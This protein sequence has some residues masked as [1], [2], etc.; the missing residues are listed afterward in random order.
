M[1]FNRLLSQ[2]ISFYGEDTKSP[3][4]AIRSKNLEKVDTKLYECVTDEKNLERWVKKLEEQSVISVD[5][6]TTSINP[7][8]AELVGLSFSYAPNKACYIPVQNKNQK[9]LSKDK[10]IKKVKSLLEDVSIKK[11]GQNLKY[12]YIVLLQEGINLQSMEDT[13]LISYTLDA[14]LNRHNLNLLSEIHLNHKTI[15]YKDLVGSGKSKLEFVDVDLKEATKYAG[16]DADITLRLFKLLKDRVDKEKLNKIYYNFEL[17]MIKLLSK[18]EINGIKIDDKYLKNLSQKFDTRI[19]ETEKKIFKLA[20]KTFNIGSPKQLGEIIYNDLKIA[21]L[22]KTKKG[23]LSTSASVLE[24]LAYSGHKFPNLV[25]TWRQ[26]SK[27]KNTYSDALQTHINSKTKRVH[28]SFLLAAT[29][30]GRLAS[31]DPNLQNIPI[32]T[33]DGKEI[34]KAFLAEKNNLLTSA[35]YSQIEMRILADLADVKELKKAFKNNEDVHSITA[36]QVFNM[37]IKKI[38]E[39]LRRKAKAINF[40]II[41][42][43]TQYGLAKQISVSNQEALDFINA[44]FKKFPEIKSYMNDTIKTCRKNGYVSNIFGRRIHLR[45]I[46]DKNFSVRSFQE[47]AAI[48]AP[49][50]SSA[51]DIIRLAMFKIDDLI[52]KDKKMKTKMLLQIHDELIFE[53]PITSKDYVEKTIKNAMI[54]VSKSDHHIFSIPLEVNVNSGYNWG[55]AH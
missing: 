18:M 41:Y 40:G 50:Q 20:G 51:A 32:K 31:S 49:I 13:M 33:E 52:E 43:I 39:D 38:S 48:N 5:T 8:E 29:N 2:A 26:L 37:P 17:P 1:E 10:V 42:G 46:N 19:K 35:D 7:V 45:G 25:L 11:V 14:G 53:S 23:S 22:K 6:E 15:S 55:E 16:E 36:S 47:R 54:S 9:I 4:Q 28:T 34:R 30:T 3:N 27:L 12:D 44:Y 24:D 21:K